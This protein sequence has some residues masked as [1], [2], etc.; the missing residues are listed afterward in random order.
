MVAGR[1]VD[2]CT[3]RLL[4]SCSVF[5]FAT[6]GVIPSTELMV[7]GSTP[8]RTRA[9][10]W[11]ATGSHWKPRRVTHPLLT[12]MAWPGQRMQEEGDWKTCWDSPSEGAVS[13]ILMCNLF[14]YVK[15]KKYLKWRDSYLHKL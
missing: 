5:L 3:S 10:L 1:Q 14:L 2:V 6:E 15:K 13:E 12:E 9:E 7:A 4:C 8:V 11:G